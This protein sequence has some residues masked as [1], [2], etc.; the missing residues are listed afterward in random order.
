[1]SGLGDGKQIF[2]RKASAQIFSTEVYIG[3]Y[4]ISWYLL[5]Q[6]AAKPQISLGFST[7]LPL[8]AGTYKIWQYSKTCLKPPL[9]NNTKTGFQY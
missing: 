1:M 5:Q 4:T 7:V 2:L 8:A 9:K 6:Q 3:Q